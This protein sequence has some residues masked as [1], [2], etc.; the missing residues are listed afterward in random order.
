MGGSFSSVI[1][2]AERVIFPPLLIEDE[3]L[4]EAK[5]AF[6]VAKKN[7]NDA[8][9]RYKHELTMYG[10]ELKDLHVKMTKIQFI[11]GHLKNE[12]DLKLPGVDLQKMNEEGWKIA[13]T[14]TDTAIQI[15]S[16]ISMVLPEPVGVIAAI[17]IPVIGDII[18]EGEQIGKFN[19]ATK[20]IKQ[21]LTTVTDAES[22]LNVIR[23]KAHQESIVLDNFNTQSLNAIGE[24]D[25]SSVQND[26]TLK[27]NESLCA[28]ANATSADIEDLANRLLVPAEKEQLMT[29]WRSKEKLQKDIE[30][31]R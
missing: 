26:K 15:A 17:V 21:N 5:A 4:N 2:V 30:S 14:V 10:T 12:P 31:I 11:T 13:S 29:L 28:L 16:L 1:K 22:K 6:N 23:A 8:I 24:A 3:V 18:Q 27:F 9:T 25:W 20:T 7:L 19:D